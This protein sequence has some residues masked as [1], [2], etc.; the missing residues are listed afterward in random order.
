M[1]WQIAIDG[2]AGSGKSTIAQAV[3]K[4]LQFE[5][6]DTGAMYRAVTLKALQLK[7]NLENEE[8]FNFLEDTKIDFERQKIYLDNQDVSKAIRSLEV[9]NH[10]SL[11]SKY[12]YV[13]KKMVA[14]Q[15]FF[16]ANKNVIMDGRD[17]GTVVLPHANLK[18]YLNA[19]VEER[20]RRR[21]KER[22]E[23]NQGNGDLETTIKE[24]IERDTKDSTRLISPLK[25]ADDA[26]EIDSSNLSVECVVKKIMSLVFERGYK[27]EKELKNENVELQEETKE[28]KE[29]LVE[30]VAPEETVET[31][32]SVKQQVAPEEVAETE[33][34]KEEQVALEE[35]TETEE[36]KEEQ[37][38]PEETVETEAV[39]ED[40]NPLEEDGDEPDITEAEEPSEEEPTKPTKYKE[41]QIVSG[42]VVEVIPEQPETKVGNR[43]IKPKEERV[44]IALEDGQEGFLFKRDTA[45]IK[46]DEDLI[47]LFC[48]GDKVDV[49]I[50]KIFPDG[51]KFI[52]ST[53]LLNKR[54]E[55]EKFGAELKRDTVFTAKVLK[56]IQVG[57]L[58]K[59]EEFSC[60]LP[61][62]QVAVP[63]EEIATLV[64]KEIS[65]APIRVDYGRIRIIVSQVL[66]DR[67]NARAEKK[68]FMEAL[69]V[70]QVYDGVV[71]N[72]EKYGAFVEIG[73][74][75]EGLLHISEIDHNRVFKVEKFLNIGDQVK[76]KVIKL[77]N[78]HIGLSR[79]ALIPNY[80]EEFTN[81]KT[82]GSFTIG[83]VLEI[84]NSGVVMQLAPEV[85]GFLP[86]SEFSWER[87]VNLEDSIKVDEE[88][89][90]KI[91]EIDAAKKRII[92]SKKQLVENPW[93][94]LSIKVGDIVDVKV[95]KILPEGFI[96]A[97]QG[98][99]GYLPKSTI[100]SI[101]PNSVELEQE[102]K[103]KVR[104]LDP[105]RNKLVLS[106]R[107]AEEK[108]E[109]EIF[110][111]TMNLQDKMSNTFGDYLKQSKNK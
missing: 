42:T 3:A 38:A 75:V 61:T 88:I 37:V 41:L 48:E 92:L 51:G 31:E 109:K 81:D 22:L 50:K 4:E 7:I 82:V 64:G 44:L 49:A 39:A 70:G 73:K 36:Q 77:E 106:M 69:E 26:I 76:V 24:I 13:R 65:V 78:E 46:E 84:N 17:I 6:I 58:M 105:E 104:V 53:V 21:M 12:G 56:Q 63:E 27:M 62:S 71:K 89:E 1:N 103:V 80:W 95:S 85:S 25:K 11:V 99:E 16:A 15:Q 34:Q 10:V 29:E 102:I 55:L 33:E 93:E 60:L 8:E 47:D 74:N 83:K 40:E 68:A 59:Y 32:V 67:I 2:P 66:A 19:N 90:V 30:Q 28:Q 35:T 86:R 110:K 43:V 14:L 108:I 18:I 79:K 23:Q 91:I 57:L 94:S 20:A 5:H 97:V 98:V 87:D 111:S 101:D 72:I 100:R 9:T 54:K 52:F 107:D 45:G 96:V